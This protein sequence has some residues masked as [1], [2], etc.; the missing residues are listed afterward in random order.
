[1]FE[2]RSECDSES[3]EGFIHVRVIQAVEEVHGAGARGADADAKLA[4]AL[5]KARRHKGGRFLVAHADVLD[6]I[7][8]LAQRFDD[9]INAITDDAEAV[10]R[11]PRDQGSTMISAVVRSGANCGDGWGTMPPE[12]SESADW[13]EARASLAV[14]PALAATIPAPSSEESCGGQYWILPAHR[15]LRA[16]VTQ[17]KREVFKPSSVL[18]EVA[19]SKM[20]D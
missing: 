20:R 16:A 12:D 18:T 9:G 4:G 2:M 10:C 15:S 1:M 3:Q 5:G 11:A 19:S 7:L 6:P 8:T 17:A 14:V 13:F